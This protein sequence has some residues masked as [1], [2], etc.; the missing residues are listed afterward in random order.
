MLAKDPQV[1]AEF[2]KKLANDKEFAG[3]AYARLNF[4][5]QRSPWW[6][7]RLGLYPVGRLDSLQGVPL[8]SAKP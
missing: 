6:D 4:F 5:Y 1:K 7:Q 2:E 3:N 8:G